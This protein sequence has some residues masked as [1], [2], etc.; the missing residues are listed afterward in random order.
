MIINNEVNIMK[1]QCKI[2]PEI[3]NNLENENQTLISTKNII[4]KSIQKIKS[5]LLEFELYKNNIERNLK[6]AN[7]LYE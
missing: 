4:Q 2:L 1:K 6:N 5:K 7:M 3:I